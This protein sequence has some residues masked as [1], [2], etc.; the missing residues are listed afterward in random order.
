MG[1]GPKELWSCGS[2]K[3]A[4]RR[5]FRHTC[6]R[7]L[8]RCYPGISFQFYSVRIEICRYRKYTP[9]E[10]SSSGTGLLFWSVVVKTQTRR[11]PRHWIIR[12]RR[13]EL[14]RRNMI[15]RT[16]H[17]KRKGLLLRFFTLIVI[18]GLALFILASTDI[19][20]RDKNYNLEYHHFVQAK[21]LFNSDSTNENEVNRSSYARSH[22]VNN[23]KSR[24]FNNNLFTRKTFTSQVNESIVLPIIQSSCSQFNFSIALPVLEPNFSHREKDLF[25]LILIMSGVGKTSFL[26][27]RN[28][29]RRTWLKS[30]GISKKWKHVF[31][32]GRSNNPKID[33]EIKR[34][35]LFHNDILMFNSTDNYQNLIT[36]V[37]SGFRWAFMQVKTRF[38]LK[39]DD[40]VYIRIP[41][42][43][44]WL[45]ESGSDCFYGGHV[46]R[47]GAQVR[48]FSDPK[49]GMENAV[50]LDC[51]AEK[52]F[53]PYSAGPFYVISSNIV[54]SLFQSMRKWK[55][56]PVED[57]YIGVLA[58][59]GDVKPVKIPGF[60]VDHN[61]NTYH[62]NCLWAS[63]IAIG[64]RFNAHHLHYLQSKLQE[65]EELKLSRIYY[66]CLL[67][68]IIMCIWIV[69]LHLALLVT[70][71]VVVLYT[72][73][74][75]RPYFR[76][77]YGNYLN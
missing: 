44:S 22:W 11:K 69:A 72:V 17:A 46:Y 51:Y 10:A 20:K 5:C 34:E 65:T 60:R 77:L 73:V 75:F 74:I 28:A 12:R 48:R 35:A 15:V 57:A 64:H 40:D 36:K 1:W 68:E 52:S 2:V 67:H 45:N 37:F 61:N 66:L 59:A 54:P 8:A 29:I 55:V 27:Q 62:H 41:H 32:L 26:D 3:I 33:S 70:V 56:F 19:P 9:H 13:M 71:I 63:S 25:L 43:I 49:L 38:I 31:L 47:S 21:A 30:A 16:H 7:D 42:L 4:T 24:D 14:C 23:D 53:P 18:I 76:K 58:N 50:N 6:N 39:A